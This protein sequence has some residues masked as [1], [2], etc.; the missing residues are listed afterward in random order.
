MINQ[1]HQD[2]IYNQLLDFIR[3]WNEKSDKLPPEDELAADLG[4]SRVKLRDILAVLEAHGYINRKKGVG[5]IINR[6][7][8]KEPA[9]LDIDA[10]YEET[11]T[12]S[13]FQAHTLVRRLQ[14]LSNT[15]AS[16]SEQLNILP[17]APTYFV[18]K[19]VFADEIPAIILQDYILPK[20]Y[21]Q[22]NIDM[23]ILA[24]STF[25][26]VQNYSKDV[27]ESLVVHVDAISAEGHVAKELQLSEGSP[28]LCLTSTGY[29]FHSVPILCSIEYHNTKILPYSFYKRLHRTHFFSASAE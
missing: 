26:F 15:P 29:S 4:I 10:I 5:T 3:L 25:S 18:E 7:L 17:D 9:R 19:V 24:K 6:C 21:N 2:D 8:L 22:N 28:L 20:Y 14:Y 11:V 1:P 27:L 16:V 12:A 23:R 13:G